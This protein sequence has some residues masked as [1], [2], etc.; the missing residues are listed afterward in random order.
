[1]LLRLNERPV[2]ENMRNYPSGLV[3]RVADLLVGGAVAEP[4]PRRKGFYDV[5][6][7]DRVFFIHISPVSGKVFLL[8]TWLAEKA[9]VPA[10]LHAANARCFEASARLA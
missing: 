7:R 1:M 9:P 2:V 4:D 3:Q 8:A 10:A 5:V 6:D